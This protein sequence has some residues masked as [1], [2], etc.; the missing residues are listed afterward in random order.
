M[1]PEEKK[2]I[3]MA[4]APHLKAIEGKTRKEAYYD[5]F[6]DGLW[7]SATYEREADARRDAKA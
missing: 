6:S 5:G 3:I 7:K 4:L 2:N 1:L